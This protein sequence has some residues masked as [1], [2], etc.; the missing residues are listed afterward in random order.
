MKGRN[1]TLSI[2]IGLNQFHGNVLKRPLSWTV[3]KDGQN[4]HFGFTNFR[5]PSSV[6][7][8]PI[9]DKEPQTQLLRVT[10]PSSTLFNFT[11]F[12]TSLGRRRRRRGRRETWW[13][14]NRDTKH[15]NRTAKQNCKYFEES[16]IDS[17]SLL[18]SFIYGPETTP[19]PFVSCRH[20]FKYWNVTMSWESKQREESSSFCWKKKWK[21]QS[22]VEM[23]VSS[24]RPVASGHYHFKLLTLFEHQFEGTQE[25]DTA[26][27]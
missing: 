17:T 12:Q 3:R 16:P 20:E 4:V 10:V 11:L 24:L 6:Y 22:G 7:F 2:K 8:L 18:S 23:Y 15:K 9:S 5:N 14:W 21:K 25:N 13:G 27:F 1:P 26:Q 19:G